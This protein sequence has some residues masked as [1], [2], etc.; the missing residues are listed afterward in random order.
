MNLDLNGAPPPQND[1]QRQTLKNMQL[2]KIVTNPEVHVG[3][4]C[5][6]SFSGLNCFGGTVF[7]DLAG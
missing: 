6:S 1:R 5:L 4:V 3:F 7:F 2:Q